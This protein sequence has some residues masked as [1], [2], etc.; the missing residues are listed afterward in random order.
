MHSLVL[1]FSSCAPMGFWISPT[2]LVWHCHALSGSRQTSATLHA[3]YICVTSGWQAD[4]CLNTDVFE[5]L[6]S[7]WR[8]TWASDRI[9]EQWQLAQLA[10]SHAWHKDIRRFSETGLEGWK[11]DLTHKDAYDAYTEQRILNPLDVF[12]S[13]LEWQMSEKDFYALIVK[14]NL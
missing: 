1:S 14:T 9:P 12:W 2:L 11:Q 7:V 10:E 6:S 8:W 13:Y 5:L 4:I 3:G